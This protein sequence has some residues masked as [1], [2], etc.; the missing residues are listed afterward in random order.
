MGQWFQT[1][2]KVVPGVLYLGTIHYE[3]AGTSGNSCLRCDQI[4]STG[5]LLGFT[6]WALLDKAL[7]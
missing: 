1:G 7:E 6:R 3:H 4:L 5:F 2:G